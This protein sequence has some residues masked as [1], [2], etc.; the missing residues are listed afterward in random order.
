MGHWAAE[1]AFGDPSYDEV[2]GLGLLWRLHTH[3]VPPRL[4]RERT[5]VHVP[6]H[7]PGW[8]RRLA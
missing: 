7:R 3:A 2:N 6:P 5:L 4:P 8:H 1:W